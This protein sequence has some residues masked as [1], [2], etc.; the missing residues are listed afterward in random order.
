MEL[1][2]NPATTKLIALLSPTGL[3][4]GSSAP[5]SP[6]FNLPAL[7]LLQNTSPVRKISP[8]SFLRCASKHRANNL[9]C[10]FSFINLGSVICLCSSCSHLVTPLPPPPLLLHCVSSLHAV[11]TS[12]TAAICYNTF[13]LL[14][15]QKHAHVYVPVP[16]TQLHPLLSEAKVKAFLTLGQRGR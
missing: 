9:P 5:W 3:V 4:L 14:I 12:L 1:W 13:V 8:N 16:P 10:P 11:A 6:S 15:S 2:V 7:L